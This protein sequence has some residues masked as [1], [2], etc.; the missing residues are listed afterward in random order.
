VDVLIAL[1]IGTRISLWVDVLI[2]LHIGTRIS[3][4]VDVLQRLVMFVIVYILVLVDIVE[5][6]SL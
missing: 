3:L 1:Q 6:L 4:W 5:T 2:A